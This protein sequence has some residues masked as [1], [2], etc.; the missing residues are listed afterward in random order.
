MRGLTGYK[1]LYFE[2]KAELDREREKTKKAQECAEMYR[3]IARE[4]QE[5]EEEAHEELHE[6]REK[7]HEARQKVHEARQQMH[8]TRGREFD[9]WK[10][11]LTSTD[12]EYI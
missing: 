12:G 4:A 11:L 8:E 5:R 6:A 9:A 3:K 7:L 10:R 2:A 1:A